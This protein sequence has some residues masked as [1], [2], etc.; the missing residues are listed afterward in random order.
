M[1]ECTKNNH[2]I[3]RRVI[4][5][6][7]LFNPGGYKTGGIK[8]PDLAMDELPCPLILRHLVNVSLSVLD[9][10]NKNS[11]AHRTWQT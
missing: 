3:Q 4:K 10:I 9:G 2:E 11:I 5:Y 8:L 6:P 7:S 1:V